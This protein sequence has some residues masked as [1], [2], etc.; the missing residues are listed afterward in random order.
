MG[1]KLVLL[2]SAAALAL[3]V[4]PAQA[5][6]KQASRIT[7]IS[8]RRTGHAHHESGPRRL[9]SV[10]PA[11]NDALTRAFRR[12]RLTA[13]EY[14]LERASSLFRIGRARDRFG[15]VERVHPRS[16]TMVLR[17]LAARIDQ[18]EGAH[19]DRARA[20]LARPTDGPGDGFGYAAGAV[21]DSVCSTN[22]CV[23]WTEGDADSP[24]LA[25]IDGNGV[26]DQVE[27]VL[28]AFETSWSVQV[29]ELGYR[30]PL[31][32]AEGPD[33]RLDVYLSDLGAD[34]FYGY[35]QPEPFDEGFVAPA[36]CGV[37]ND[38]SA[39]QFPSMS[40][41]PALQAT[42]A[43]EFFHAVQSGYDFFED[44]WMSEGTAAWMEDQ[45]FDDVND[46][47]Q[48]L[49]GSQLRFPGVPLDSSRPTDGYGYQSWLW[50][51]HLTEQFDADII[52]QIWT[53]AAAF[54]G[55]PD[56]YSL[57]AVDNVLWNQH[58]YSFRAA[59]ADFTSFNNFAEA[60]YQEGPQYVEVAGYPPAR[61]W[62]LTRRRPR[63]K[64]APVLNHL[65]STNF[66]VRPGRG[67]SRSA[68]L[69]LILDLP[70][71]ATGPEATAIVWKRDN[72]LAVKPIRI[73][74]SGD[75]V[76]KVAFGRGTVRS[77][78]VTLTNASGRFRDCWSDMSFTY[79]CA[80][81]PRDDRRSYAIKAKV[82]R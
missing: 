20:V 32:D 25:D 27:Q 18:L 64:A 21:T 34:G 63:K 16:M 26:P 45:V 40:G 74:N 55:A 82:V 42:A 71:R 54:S 72:S 66:D 60:W 30:A 52:R 48:Y 9:P 57:Q 70:K 76:V 44:I 6:P 5:A 13:A 14:S 81:R 1:K 65:T 23:T 36:S 68:R 3:A 19:L 61:S 7:S 8:H 62:K 24:P 35:C 4:V 51:Q 53:R 56:D 11:P 33:S 67:V 75:A 69:K 58:D 50:W 29:G 39:A 28:E 43:H 47:Y 41:L 49:P 17:D 77:V 73:S 15:E 59:F 10:A 38:F 31:P 46:N 2:F 37:D 22:L 78:F 12:G 80:G 79:T